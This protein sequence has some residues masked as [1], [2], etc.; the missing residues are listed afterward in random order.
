MMILDFYKIHLI[1][2]YVSSLYSSR[3]A[4]ECLHCYVLYPVQA[5]TLPPVKFRP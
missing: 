3:A 5:E 4:D 2:E 1:A